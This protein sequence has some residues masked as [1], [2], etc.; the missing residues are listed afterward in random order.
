MESKPKTLVVT[1]TNSK[2]KKKANIPKALREQVWIQNIGNHFEHKCLVEWCQNTMN[3][4]NYHVGHNI[5]E[6]H[7]GATNIK[8]LKPICARCNL[9]MGSQYSIEEWSKMGKDMPQKIYRNLVKTPSVTM[10]VKRPWW[11]C[12]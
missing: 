5:P 3:V 6:S 4:F 10:P 8:N 7:G 1:N 2:T 11:L 12:C 9:S